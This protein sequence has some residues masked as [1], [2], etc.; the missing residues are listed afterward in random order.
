[1]MPNTIYSG[2]K[3]V[4]NIFANSIGL[5]CVAIKILVKVSVL[6]Q[7][8]WPYFVQRLLG[9]NVVES[10]SHLRAKQEQLMWLIS[11]I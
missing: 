2:S 7:R 11:A 1:M 6:I 10:R 5:V 9:L 8:G 4:C 3:N